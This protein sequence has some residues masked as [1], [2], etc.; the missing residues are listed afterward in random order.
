[1]MTEGVPVRGSW[2]LIRGWV[3]SSCGS[4]ISSLVHRCR[5]NASCNISILKSVSLRLLLHRAGER[6]RA[7]SMDNMKNVENLEEIGTDDIE[8]VSLQ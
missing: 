8:L 4:C 2:C 6:G 1:M 5:R 7:R 3:N